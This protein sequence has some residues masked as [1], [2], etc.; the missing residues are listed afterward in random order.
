MKEEL[1]K[2]GFSENEARTYL[3]LLKVGQTTTTIL[4]KRLHIHRGY[5][6]DIL[7]KLIEKGIVSVIKKNGKKHFEAHSPNEILNFINEQ[8]IKLENYEK[9]FNKILPELNNL[10]LNNKQNILLFE[11]KEALKNIF[12]DIIIQ[13]RDIFVFGASGKLP[14][15]MENYYFRWNRQR[16]KNKINLRIIYNQRQIAEKEN[17]VEE[18]KFVEKRYLEFDKDN[19]SSTMLYA[20]KLAIIIWIDRPLITLIESKEAYELYKNYFEAFWKLA[21][22]I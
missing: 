10:K 1:I 18:T 9:D 14:N 3:E 2:L 22:E 15:E 13:K 4:A 8:K 16:V 19:P 17:T 5:I 7:D 20:D 11:G 12:E 21:K 6:Y